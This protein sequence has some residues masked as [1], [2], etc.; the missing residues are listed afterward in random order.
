[1][2]NWTLTSTMR[3]DE[4]SLLK[5]KKTLSVISISRK[6]SL[7]TTRESMYLKNENNDEKFMISNK[8]FVFIIAFRRR[9]KSLVYCQWVFISCER[10]L[11]FLVVLSDKFFFFCLYWTIFLLEKENRFVL[12]EMQLS[13]IEQETGNVKLVSNDLEQWPILSLSCIYLLPLV[14]NLSM[15]ERRDD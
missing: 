3:F 14:R 6:T 10:L 5:S 8:C 1:M 9:R 7:I 4:D 2:N 13:L 12:Y 15:Y 11:F